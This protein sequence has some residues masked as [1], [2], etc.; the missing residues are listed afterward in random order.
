MSLVDN[1]FLM[2]PL[3]DLLGGGD[4]PASRN[5]GSLEMKTDIKED[6]TNY[7]M[8]VE[9]PGIEKK[10]ISVALE[11]GYLTVGVHQ[12]TTVGDKDKKGR[13]LH[14]ERFSG[15]ASRTFY[16]GDVKEKDISASFNNGIL[17]LSFPKEAAKEKTAEHRIEIK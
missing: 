17:S 15:S 4:F 14:R 6:G 3:F 7:V 12:D 1:G 9:L 16:V 5:L 11:N 2:D 10:D 8:E 13:Y